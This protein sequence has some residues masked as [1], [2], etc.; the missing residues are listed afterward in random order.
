[1]KLSDLDKQRTAYHLAYDKDYAIASGILNRFNNNCDRIILI[2]P[3]HKPEVLRWLT[4]PSRKAELKE[5]CA[6]PLSIRFGVAL[7]YLT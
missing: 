5:A 2:V 3:E 1:M 6:S 7:F 4:C